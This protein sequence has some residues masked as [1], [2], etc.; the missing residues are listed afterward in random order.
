MIN[1]QINTKA[2]DTTDPDTIPNTSVTELGDTTNSSKENNKETQNRENLETGNMK[3]KQKT[4]PKY[5]Q[6]S[7]LKMLAKARRRVAT[8]ERRKAQKEYH[9]LAKKLE[10]INTTIEEECKAIQEELLTEYEDVFSAKLTRDQRIKCQPVKLELVKNSEDLPKPNRATA[11]RCPVNLRK[12]SDELVED[13]L[14]SGIIER[15][16][17]HTEFTSSGSFIPKKSDKP[18]LVIYYR[19][20]NKHI[21]CPQWPMMSMDEIKGKILPSWRYFFSLDLTSGYYQ[22]PLDNSSKDIIG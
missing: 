6:I 13:L 8:L 22:V 11:R 15:V 20:A 2:S 19:V 10:K 21:A 4:Q 1:N 5:K 14:A 12:S 3:K 16:L 7:E 9:F 17:H 18:R